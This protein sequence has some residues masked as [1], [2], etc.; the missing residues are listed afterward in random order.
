MGEP[1]RTAAVASW[2]RGL[3]GAW[4]ANVGLYGLAIL[5]L[6]ALVAQIVA[7]GGGTPQ[8]V[9]V[10]SRAPATTVPT[11][12]LQPTTTAA[13]TT[14]TI[15]PA[16]TVAPAPSAAPAP[17]TPA[18][19]V[20]VSVDP[21]PPPENTTIPGPVCRNSVNPDCGPLVWDPPLTNQNLTVSVVS[22]SPAAPKAG[23]TVSFT[24]RVTDPDHRVTANCAVADYNGNGDGSAIERFSCARPSC[25]DAHGPWDPP[26]A[27][28]ETREFTFNHAYP[29]GSYAPVF[30]FHT[31]SDTPCPNPYGSVGQ[32]SGTNLTVSP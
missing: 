1:G 15:G 4:R 5:A 27:V 20:P 17:S 32:S 22:V 6:V 25:P 18:P 16:T 8:R 9:E 24:L 29:Q 14:T 7:G 13:P 2:W 23:D 31:D 12:R 28:P 26:P 30:I 11:S 10:A 21:P 3:T 19:P